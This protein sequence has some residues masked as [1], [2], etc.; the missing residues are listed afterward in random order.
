MSGARRVLVTGASRGIGRVVARRLARDG[1]AVTACARDAQALGEVVAAL[2]GGGHRLLALDVADAAAWAGA[3]GDLDAVAG[4]VCAAGILGPI[5]DLA[6]IDP[7][8]FARALEVN[9]AGTMLTL[10]SCAPA[11]RAAEGAA[12]VLSGGGA[13]GPLARFD[14]YAA[15]K[16]AVVRSPRTPPRAVSASTRSLPGS[17]SPTCSPRC[18]T[19]GLPGAARPTMSG[20]AERS[21]RGPT[22][23]RER[24][25]IA[26]LLSDDAR[27]ISG[28]LLSATWD[29]WKDEDFRVWL[30]EEPDLATLRCINDQSFTVAAGA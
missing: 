10:Q 6:D 21:T 23:L 4:V 15:S 20:C 8:L 17:S 30:R 19:P 5:G 28:R 26:F 3:A 18:S 11:L 25:R 1:Y 16:A 12:V 29:R 2:P 27:G 9:V 22:I 13:T 7:A 14:A 24:R